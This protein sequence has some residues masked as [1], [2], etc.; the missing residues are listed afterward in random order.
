M[1]I[2]KQTQSHRY[3]AQS[4]DTGGERKVVRVNAGAGV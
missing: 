4:I 3:R 1:N 2:T